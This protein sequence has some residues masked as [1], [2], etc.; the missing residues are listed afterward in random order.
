MTMTGVWGGRAIGLPELDAAGACERDERESQ[1]AFEARVRPLLPRLNRFCL[2]LCRDRAEAE[3]LLQDGLVRAFQHRRSFMGH[4]MLLGWLCGILRNQ[5]TET[6]RSQARRR[7]LLD[8]A[9][10]GCTEVL[11]SMFGGTEVPS[12][13]VHACHS[14]ATAQ[15]YRCLHGMPEAFRMAVLLCDVEELSYEEAAEALGVPVGTVKSR[16]FRGRKHLSTAFAAQE[17]MS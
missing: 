2:M 10:T 11:G 16:H 7:S 12:P 6:R 9:L 1:R 14:E 17:K 4:G 13:E 5:F 15:L 8:R 3:D